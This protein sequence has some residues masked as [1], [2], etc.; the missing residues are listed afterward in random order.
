MESRGR[1]GNAQQGSIKCWEFIEQFGD[2]SS[3][4]KFQAFKNELSDC[5]FLQKTFAQLI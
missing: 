2:S 5:Y 1:C 4:M 3:W